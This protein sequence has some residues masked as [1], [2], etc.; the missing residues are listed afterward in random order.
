MPEEKPK[1][2]VNTESDTMTI[3]DFIIE[4]IKFFVLALVIVLPIRAYVA[5]PFIV[6]GT[7]MVPTFEDGQYLIIDELSYRFH[8]PARGDVII[9]K[10]PLDP[11]K[12]FIKRVIG[13]PGET[14]TIKNGDVSITEAGGKTITL[15]QSYVK[16]PR[17]DSE[18]S[19]LGKDE[20]W[21]MG[22]NR[23]ASS[24]SRSWG[25][26]TREHIVGVA[27][28]RLFPLSGIS[29]LPGKVTYKN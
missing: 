15:D 1:E 18:I 7:S 3:K 14:V 22:D 24:D 16:F 9:F 21:V 25:A 12:F 8:E 6:S 20:Y 2:N 17:V 27:A 10:Y 5:Q 28:L 13:L 26:I 23:S 4:V 19:I 29:V 11:S